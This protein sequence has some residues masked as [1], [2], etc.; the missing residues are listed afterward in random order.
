MIPR[1]LLSLAVVVGIPLIAIAQPVA[2]AI[3]F[4]LLVFLMAATALD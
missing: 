1:V 3:G 4:S 2:F